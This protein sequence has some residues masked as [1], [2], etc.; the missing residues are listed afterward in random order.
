M[1]REKK[2]KET[3]EGRR[4][5][6]K[7]NQRNEYMYSEKSQGVVCFFPRSLTE[8]WRQS[9]VTKSTSLISPELK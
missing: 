5:R 7:R 3:E 9:E 2:G 8:V 6:R 1:G 4:K